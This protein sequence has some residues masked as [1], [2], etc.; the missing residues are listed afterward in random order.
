MARMSHGFEVNFG[1]DLQL[2]FYGS[3]FASTEDDEGEHVAPV[4]AGNELGKR[5]VEVDFYPA[6]RNDDIPYLESGT[7]RWGICDE[8]ESSCPR[9]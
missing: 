9:T 1:S 7:Y 3:L 6:H 5:I 8:R 4:V 2:H